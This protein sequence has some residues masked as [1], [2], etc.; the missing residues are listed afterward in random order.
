MEDR[1]RAP[2]GVLAERRV[3]QVQLVAGH[4]PEESIDVLVKDADVVVEEQ[5]PMFATA[6]TGT[7]KSAPRIPASSAPTSSAAIATSAWSLVTRP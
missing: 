5:L 7:A 6:A 2:R 3:S 4:G 1:A